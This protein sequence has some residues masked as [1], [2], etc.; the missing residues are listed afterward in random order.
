MS[1]QK[2]RTKKASPKSD[3]LG[4]EILA[5]LEEFTEALESGEVAAHLRKRQ[6]KIRTATASQKRGTGAKRRVSPKENEK[7]A[8]A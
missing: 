4:K 8:G 6:A 5:A 2:A 3:S 1:E 7:A